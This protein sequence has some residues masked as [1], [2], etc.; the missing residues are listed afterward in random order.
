MKKLSKAKILEPKNPNK[1]TALFGG[2]ASGILNYDD[3]KYPHFYDIRKTIR[4]MF[5]SSSE[6][7]MKPDIKQFPSLSEREQN[8]F[9]KII[10]LLAS[11]DG[12]QTNIALRLAQYTTDP[13]V[14]AIFSTIADQENE[15]N[16][17]YSYVLSSVVDYKRQLE[18][19]ETGR[20]DEVLLERNKRLIEVY[21]DFAENPTIDKIPKVIVYTSLLEGLYFYSGFAYFYNLARN[22]KMVS[23]STMISYI[24]R[25][26][27]YHGRFA[28]ELFRAVLAEHPELNNDKLIDWV[29]DQFK[30]STEQEIKWSEYILTG[31]EGIDLVEMAGFVKYRANKMLRMLG[32][33][34]LYEGY[35]ENPMKWIRAY[36]DNFDDT[37]SD[38][39]EQ[40][41]RTY[42]KSTDLNGFDAL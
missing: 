1:S 2:K 23:T 31:I 37:K 9:L 20:T 30:Y 15:H 39:F 26:E 32:L 27:M 3:L 8:A 5:W 34:D 19:F 35:E 25:D 36:A 11:F 41:P 6:I 33:K 18:S 17:S 28:T 40:K 4:S 12:P 42:T 10:G 38:F 14:V 7:D 21:N 16:L 13:S 22:N 29:Y 24:N